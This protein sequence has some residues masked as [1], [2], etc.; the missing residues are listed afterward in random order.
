MRRKR[1]MFATYDITPVPK[2]NESV[3][4]I[5]FNKLVNMKLAT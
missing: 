4:I 5:D 2:K 1:N 3:T